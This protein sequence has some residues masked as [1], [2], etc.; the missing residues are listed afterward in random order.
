MTYKGSNWTRGELGNVPDQNPFVPCF[1]C[2]T[3]FKWQDYWKVRY[4]DGLDFNLHETALLCDDCL[5][6][7]REEYDLYKRKQQNAS[8]GEFA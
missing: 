6:R 8:L 2:G 5:E 7:Y 1:D 3:D 4:V